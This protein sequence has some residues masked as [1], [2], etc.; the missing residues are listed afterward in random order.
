MTHHDPGHTVLAVPVPEL[1]D[2]VRARTAHYDRDYVAEDPRFGQAHITILA[3][4]VRRPTAADLAAVAQVAAQTPTFE[5]RLSELGT[6]PNGII[7]LVPQPMDAFAALTAAVVEL[8]PDYP[9]YAGQFPR[10]TP[11]VTLDAVSPDITQAEVRVMLGDLVP[12]TAQADCVQV[13]WWQAGHC[14]V[15]HTWQLGHSP[16]QGSR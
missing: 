5:Y 12:L 14:H 6:F 13:Q 9:P 3:P 8:F 1:N 4:W 11:H 10:V 16:A 2:F 15:Q 7:H